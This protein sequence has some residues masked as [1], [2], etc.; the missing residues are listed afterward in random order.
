MYNPLL[1]LFAGTVI[2]IL[3][4][5]V[6]IPQKG[7]LAKIRKNKKT[8]KKEA[9]ED[10]LKFIHD[11]EYKNKEC[12]YDSIA[13]NLNI[14]ANKAAELV[15]NLV[16]MKLVKLKGKVVQLTSNGREYALKIIRI[17]RLWE[18][19]LADE[20]DVKEVE[21]HSRAHELEH[22]ISGEEAEELSASLGNPFLDPHGSPIPMTDGSIPSQDG[23]IL[24]ELEEGEFA[25]ITFI[26]DEP[27]A[28]YSQIVAEGLHVGIQI[29][30]LKSTEDKV[31]F[32]AEGEEHIL[33]PMFA[34]NILVK[35]ITNKEQIEDHKFETLSKLN[36]GDRAVILNISNSC[37]GQQRRRLMDFGFVPGSEVKVL[38]QATTGD[39]TAYQIH[40]STVAL[41]KQHS[42]M[43]FIKRYGESA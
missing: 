37:R 4:I 34:K 1:T 5:Y 27:E 19:Y 25:S 13:G 7:I 20:T 8:S 30:M 9:I 18:R 23:I 6:F 15:Q 26:D 3:L 10:A 39:P 33:A 36:K 29:Q 28:V 41:R 43:I 31:R 21:W 16:N 22:K 40:G 35:K 32:S 2:I 17:H 12:N 38:M 11:C 42:D 24:S 14:S